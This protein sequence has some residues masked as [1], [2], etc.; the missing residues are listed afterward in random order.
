MLGDWWA[1]CARTHVVSAQEGY[2]LPLAAA[3]TLKAPIAAEPSGCSTAP[4]WKRLALQRGGGGDQDDK[5]EKRGMRLR[6]KDGANQSRPG[7]PSKYGAGLAE[8][9]R[10]LPQA[11]PPA[12]ATH[13]MVLSACSR[14]K[15]M[16]AA[17][18]RCAAQRRSVSSA[19]SQG[20]PALA[21]RT[22]RGS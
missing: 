2:A 9:R 5:G 4:V 10:A 20:M 16:R 19:A 18:A 6:C 22:R 15:A 11:K 17:A 8:P 7:L 14:A 1:I 13:L 3:P 21:M 12:P